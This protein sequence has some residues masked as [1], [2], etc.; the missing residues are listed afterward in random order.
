MKK[1]LYYAVV[2]AIVAL[3]SSCI[4]EV[5]PEEGK[6]KVN[7]SQ[8]F[9]AIADGNI[10]WVLDGET[11]ANGSKY[12]FKATRSGEKRKL[13]A[14]ERNVLIP[15]KR[16]W[17]IEVTQ[18]CQ[19]PPGECEPGEEETISCGVGACAGNTGKKV[20]NAD[21]EW[22]VASECD[23]LDGATDEICNDID[24]D[25]DGTV[26]EGLSCGTICTPGATR[27][28][29]CNAVGACAGNTGTETCSADG[30][31][32]EE[33]EACDPTA[34]ATDETCNDI[35]DDCDGSVDEGLSCGAICSAGE[36]R[37]TTCNAVGACAGNTGTETCSADGMSWEETDVCDPTAGATAEICND[38]DDDCDGD[39]DEGDVCVVETSLDPPAIS[40]SD[41]DSGLTNIEIEWDAVPGATYYKIHMA[42]TIDG[43]YDVI[44]DHHTGT[45]LTYVEEWQD[46]IDEVGE[47][48]L[49]TEYNSR[50][51]FGQGLAEYRA[52]IEP[53]MDKY[54]NVHYFKI[55][56]CDDETCGDLGDAEAGQA[57]FVHTSEFSDIAQM[58]INL[59]GYPLLTCLANAP[60]GVGALGWP[61]MSIDGKFGGSV[62]ATLQVG[63]RVQVNINYNDYTDGYS[64]TRNA[65]LNGFVGGP[66]A[67]GPAMNGVVEV[68]GDLTVTGD[69]P[70]IIELSVYSFIASDAAGNFQEPNKGTI[71]VTYGGVTYT[72]DLPV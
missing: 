71:D 60:S 67:L 45:S 3:V 13:M 35:D 43:E 47:P 70:G 4:H 9:E 66:Q 72:Y 48:P 63:L 19:E 24:D 53:L 26:D 18:G 14:R 36:T 65:I 28:T 39:V 37:T 15:G 32:W 2:I 29:T 17:R 11:V 33:T 12:T 38:I 62:K 23:P 6:V 40:A 68:E 51:A 57:E 5:D 22:E 34:G 31:S 16:E 44:A 1:M 10:I 7:C 59:M 42:Q 20:C 52:S 58:M 41:L 27:T 8:T 56:A 55:Q 49:L 21:G 50:E 54:K 69:F 61:G 46:V 25:C 64:G 30:M